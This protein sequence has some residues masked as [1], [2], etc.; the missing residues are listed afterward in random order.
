MPRGCHKPEFGRCTPVSATLPTDWGCGI[1]AGVIFGSR[2][3]IRDVEEAA[4]GSCSYVKRHTLV[5]AVAVVLSIENLAKTW[6]VACGSGA[7][8]FS[9]EV[10][11]QLVNVDA[12]RDD[13]AGVTVA[14]KIRGMRPTV[15]NRS[16]KVPPKTV[17]KCGRPNV[18]R[19]RH[20]C[21][22]DSADPQTGSGNTSGRV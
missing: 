16:N 17:L 12:I 4:R 6:I 9:D 18:G 15:Q 3:G 20:N 14:N 21:R 10:A 7:G 5:V 11:G 8:R 19:G 13:A 1:P 22:S 2:S